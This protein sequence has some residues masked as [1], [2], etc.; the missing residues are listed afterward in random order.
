MERLKTR[1][2]G[3]KS[4]PVLLTDPPS[5]RE[6]PTNAPP[7]P[8]PG[9]SPAED[10]DRTHTKTGRTRQDQSTISYSARARESMGTTAASRRT[11][12]FART[13]EETSS[14]SAAASSTTASACPSPT[15]EIHDRHRAQKKR[16][17][18]EKRSHPRLVKP[19]PSA[20]RTPQLLAKSSAPLPTSSTDYQRFE[21]LGSPPPPPPKDVK[22][23]K[24]RKRADSLGSISSVS[25]SL[26]S[27][28][29]SSFDMPRGRS[30]VRDS[31]LS[32][33]DGMKPRRQKEA[34]HEWH[35]RRLAAHNPTSYSLPP[36]HM[37]RQPGGS[38]LSRQYSR[39]SSRSVASSDNLAN[40]PP[41][42]FPSN[43]RSR[44]P[45]VKLRTPA[46]IS[47]SR[48]GSR[49][50][51]RP[52]SRAGS[53][54]VD[55]HENRSRASSRAPSCSRNPSRS[56]L[57]D[58]TT[59]GRVV[60][61]RDEASQTGTSPGA[62]SA[63]SPGRATFGDYA[64][65][66]S[67]PAIASGLNGREYP[68]LA[69]ASAFAYL[70]NLGEEPAEP[71]RRR[72][73]SLIGR[74]RGRQSGDSQ[75]SQVSNTPSQYSED[76]PRSPS[77]TRNLKDAAKAAFRRSTSR[78][79]SF[80]RRSTASDAPAPE[81]GTGGTTSPFPDL[82]SA[83]P[84]FDSASPSAPV[85]AEFESAP[86]SGRRLPIENHPLVDSAEVPRRPQT[87]IDPHT[88]RP[89]D[90]SSISSFETS[91]SRHQSSTL[92]PNTSRSQSEKGAISTAGPG[93][94]QKM[95]CGSVKPLLAYT[96]LP[97]AA[98]AAQ[99][100]GTPPVGKKSSR[101]ALRV[102]V[103]GKTS[104]SSPKSP[105]ELGTPTIS[106]AST[107]PTSSAAVEGVKTKPEGAVRGEV[108][109]SRA[110][111]NVDGTKAS[112]P[113]RYRRQASPVDTSMVPKPLNISPQS[114]ESMDSMIPHKLRRQAKSQHLLTDDTAADNAQDRQE[115]PSSHAGSP[116]EKQTLASSRAGVAS[117][118]GVKVPQ[119]AIPSLEG[120]LQ[121]GSSEGSNEA[122]SLSKILLRCCGCGYFHDVPHRIYDQMTARLEESQEGKEERSAEKARHVRC[123]WCR[124]VL[125]VKCCAG[126]MAV[127]Q[128]K[129]RLH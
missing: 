103:G 98:M 55:F 42:S 118:G 77:A 53:P 117:N 104:S 9:A 105:N 80:R 94:N 24:S 21:T 73:S 93:N 76:M 13:S 90:H 14:S 39:S 108:A 71:P 3:A 84:S 64:S 48:S 45:P 99:T 107:T 51:S 54:G 49:S 95:L 85:P 83:E 27:K 75:G 123:P 128:L 2:A 33:L 15:W 22:T 57:N 109:Q 79:S 120:G 114:D 8:L 96:G 32:F 47:R 37:Y 46:P 78:A 67:N 52:G 86:A 111:L 112:T 10:G 20:S 60:S 121:R 122:E 30:S 91:Q 36:H 26:T 58:L 125:G 18:A 50:G 89:W 88:I 23:A 7:T 110:A 124:H 41:L 87:V 16:S 11:V 72:R 56:G 101:R 28:I 1:P 82:V 35:G 65:N 68:P 129:E 102:N 81:S 74:I 126:Y 59:D 63:P 97:D 17:A 119:T 38:G 113:P 43:Q 116:R 29:R 62:S 5:K 12:A 70:A 40:P 19:P 6:S 66:G 100:T 127:V 34:E 92:T 4:R 44:G 69:S 25:S 31:G 115:T 61:Y 106:S